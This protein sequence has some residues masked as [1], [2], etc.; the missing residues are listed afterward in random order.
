[1][2]TRARRYVTRLSYGGIIG[3]PPERR[4]LMAF[5]LP[6]STC[7]G[8]QCAQDPA[9][10]S[11]ARCIVLSVFFTPCGSHRTETEPVR[12]GQGISEILAL[13]L[14]SSAAGA[15]EFTGAKPGIVTTV[16]GAVFNLSENFTLLPPSR[17]GVSPGDRS[18]VT[19]ATAVRISK[20]S[21][22]GL[23]IPVRHRFRW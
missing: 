14:R 23:R 1:M 17:A 18:E 8:A 2:L 9:P 11:P 16:A 5:P 15:T 20:N 22:L 3:P 7:T 4:V 19:S 13:R 10:L 12:A 6:P 21:G